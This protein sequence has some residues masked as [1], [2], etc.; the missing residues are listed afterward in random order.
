[1]TIQ[2]TTDNNISNNE[3]LR[4]HVQGLI[5]ASLK[6][7]S[8]HITHIIVHLSDENAQKKGP[9]DLRCVI[10][11]HHSGIQPVAVVNHAGNTEQAIKGAIDKIKGSLDSIIGKMRD[12]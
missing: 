4:E 12:R 3:R 10:E 6:R 2:V 1:M 9:D 11:A 7:F 8:E 5:E